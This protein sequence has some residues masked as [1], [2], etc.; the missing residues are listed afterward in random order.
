MVKDGK[1]EHT[2]NKLRFRIYTN[3]VIL[4]EMNKIFDIYFKKLLQDPSQINESHINLGE[5]LVTESLKYFKLFKNLHNFENIIRE[6]DVEL[7]D[8]LIKLVELE[9][10][11]IIEQIYLIKLENIK[12]NAGKEDNEEYKSEIDKIINSDTN[13]ISKINKLNEN[14]STLKNTYE[15]E[16]FTEKYDTNLNYKITEID[17]VYNDFKDKDTMNSEDMSEIFKKYLELEEKLKNIREEIYQKKIEGKK[18]NMTPEQII[19]RYQKSIFDMYDFS[20][21]Q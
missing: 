7:K 13:F 14:L 11:S 12:F 19:D 9:T 1:N 10:G 21:P 16:Q 17:N 6:K 3:T 5:T 2:I 15:L 8:K 18:L 20:K 4:Y